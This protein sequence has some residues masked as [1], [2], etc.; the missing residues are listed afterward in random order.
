MKSSTLFVA[1]DL[2][3]SQT[4]VDYITDL[5]SRTKTGHPDW[6]NIFRDSAKQHARNKVDV[7]FCGLPGLFTQLKSFCR[8]SKFS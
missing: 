7:F 5:K 6:D 4:Q 1:M 3:H 8:K 2:M